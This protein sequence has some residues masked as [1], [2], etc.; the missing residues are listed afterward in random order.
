LKLII[1]LVAAAMTADLLTFWLVVPLVGIGAEQNPI[2]AEGYARFGM[3]AVAVLKF[4]ALLAILLLVVRIRDRRRRWVAASIG[5]FIGMFGAF[6]N[7]AAWL[8]TLP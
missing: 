2:M 6:G 3:L 4:A 5:I 7:T 1:A 8:S